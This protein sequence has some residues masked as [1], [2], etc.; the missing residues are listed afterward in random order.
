MA[1]IIEGP[2]RYIAGIP[3][4]TPYRQILSPYF[5]LSYRSLFP[6]VNHNLWEFRFTSPRRYAVNVANPLKSTVW[7]EDVREFELTPTFDVSSG[8]MTVSVD[9]PGPE[10]GI[11]DSRNLSR[12]EANSLAGAP[13]SAWGLSAARAGGGAFRWT[14]RGGADWEAAGVVVIRA[15]VAEL[16]AWDYDDLQNIE[17]YEGETEDAYFERSEAL[18]DAYLAGRFQSNRHQDNWYGTLTL[19]CGFAEEPETPRTGHS[20]IAP[21]ES[22]PV[23]PR[24]FVRRPNATQLLVSVSLDSWAY[25]VAG[26]PL[27]L[28]RS[29]FNVVTD[30]NDIIQSARG[31]TWPP[32]WAGPGLIPSGVRVLDLVETLDG[33]VLRYDLVTQ[34]GAS[35]A[36][37]HVGFVTIDLVSFRTAMEGRIHPLDAYSDSFDRFVFVP[38][39]K[40]V[41]LEI[42]P[43]DSAKRSKITRAGFGGSTDIYFDRQ[44]TIRAT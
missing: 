26:L 22:W 44:L 10:G 28:D 29:I 30:L 12:F 32:A 43:V 19:T 31:S 16:K 23:Y 6:A 25:Q 24:V 4:E 1:G 5:F 40:G 33:S 38:I 39:R 20:Y 17:P 3:D 15:W 13:L 9:V 21:V 14:F 36:E 7:H 2:F 42:A 27:L 37:T 41:T 11:T 18:I 8:Q 34:E 35:P